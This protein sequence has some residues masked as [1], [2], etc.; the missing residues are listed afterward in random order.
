MTADLS[1]PA[2]SPPG[3]RSVTVLFFAG[4]RDAT[5]TT[6]AS[7]GSAGQTVAELTSELVAT[8]GQD[9]G[10]L[11][12]TCAIWVNGAPAPPSRVLRARDEVAVLPPVSGGAC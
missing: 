8:Y 5:G 3:D 9:L 1:G 10:R 6:S 2:Q 7:F 12:N 11:L 4:A